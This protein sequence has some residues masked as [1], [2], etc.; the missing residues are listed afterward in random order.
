[1]MTL[2]SLAADISVIIV[3]DG[4]DEK[5]FDPEMTHYSFHKGNAFR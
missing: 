5:S 2:D 3:D 4:N 1:M